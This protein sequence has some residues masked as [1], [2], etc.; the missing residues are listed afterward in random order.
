MEW[1]G[2]C[3]LTPGKAALRL[4]AGMLAAMLWIGVIG[5][6]SDHHA[7]VG[8]AGTAGAV[9]DI[10]ALPVGFQPEGVAVSGNSIFVGSIPSGQIYEADI[11]TGQGRV[12]VDSVAGRNSIGLKV[13]DLGRLFV[14]GGQTGQAYVYDATTGADIAVFTLAVGTT[15]IN[16][17]IVTPQAAWFT[18]SQNP[19]LYRV[20][21][22]PD[23][24]LG[25][26][27]EVTS[28]PLSGDIQF[29]P[30]QFN[31]NGIAAVPDGSMLIIVQSNT[32]QLFTVDP[33]TGNTSEILLGADN[34]LNGDGILLEGRT[35][36]VVQ[37]QLNQLAV[38][39]LAL[40]FATGVVNQPIIDPALDV[41][42]T[43]AASDASLYLVNARFGIANPEAADYSIVRVDKP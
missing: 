34:V 43:V 12:L 3:L 19:V 41:P 6:G 7:P 25:T 2:K 14:A 37:N 31:A 10:I 8:T 24:S 28:V 27:A 32:G 9:P 17:V 33:A 26:P 16:D 30:D 15:F 22:N 39:T 1:V 11:L 4:L 40:D 42:T 5:C 35:L 29:V 20:P 23:G 13:D 36:F 18:D 38:I 21:I